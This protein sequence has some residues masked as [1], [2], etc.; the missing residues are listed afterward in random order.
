MR[1][2]LAIAA[3]P[4]LDPLVMRVTMTPPMLANADCVL[5]LVTG[6]E[7]ADAARRAFAE[8]PS[9]ATPASRIRSRDGQT[10]AVLDR[11]AAAQ[12]SSI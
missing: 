4:G 10:I 2:R 3:E 9:D 8:P 1:A 7:K 5:F 12:L 11:A 6:E